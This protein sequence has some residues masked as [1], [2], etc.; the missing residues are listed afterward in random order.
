MSTSRKTAAQRKRWTIIGILAAVVLVAVALAWYYGPRGN[1]S[2]TVAPNDYHPKASPGKGLVPS[3]T[4]SAS[5]SPTPT[6]APTNGPQSSTDNKV[7]ISAPAQG[8]TV[9]DGTTVSGTATTTSGTLYYRLKGGQSGQ[10]ASGQISI[11]AGQA[12]PYSFQLGFT[13]QVATGGDQGELEVY[14]VD[15]NGTATSIA[16]VAV[17]IK[18]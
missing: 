9:T 13:N 7:V 1:H 18:G 2:N 6:I 17:N 5:P 4:S 11:A 10:L 14:T 16:S 3:P 8:D 15:A 12:S